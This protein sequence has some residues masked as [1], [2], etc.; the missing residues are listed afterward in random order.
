MRCSRGGR[1][2]W[3][4]AA[5]R[6]GLA[7][8]WPP[9]GMSWSVST[10]AQEAPRDLVR[11]REDVRGDLTRCRHRLSKLLLRQG[12]VYS[13]GHAWTGKHD[14]WLRTQTLDQ[15]GR[16]LAFDAAYEAM[17]LTSQRRDRLDAA[18]TAM[19]LGSEL[20]ACCR[21]HVEKP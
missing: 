9:A 14:G 10:V 16:A 13:G 15:P 21:H 19:A 17:L 12:I 5:G 1:V 3:M 2:C 8:H 7:P 18:I 6:D 20:V 4:P 11:A